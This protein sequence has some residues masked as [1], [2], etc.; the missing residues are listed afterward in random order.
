MRSHNSV[1]VTVGLEVEENA[2]AVL[3]KH[4]EELDDVEAAS[5]LAEGFD[6]RDA[7]SWVVVVF[8]A[9]EDWCWN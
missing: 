9:K 7:A 5:E 4:A 6:M 1:A 2:V 3:W 8:D